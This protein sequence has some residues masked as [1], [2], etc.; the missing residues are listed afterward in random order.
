MKYEL[1]VWGPENKA[2]HKQ[3]KL[4]KNNVTIHHDSDPSLFFLTRV[5]WEIFPAGKFGRILDAF[6]SDKVKVKQITGS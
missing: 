4:A 3:S 6:F 2:Y 1:Q 5:P